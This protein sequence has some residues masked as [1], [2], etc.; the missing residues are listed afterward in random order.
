MRFYII[1]ATAAVLSWSTMPQAQTLVE[2]IRT[3]CSTE[4]KE[5][6]KAYNTGLKAERAGDIATAINLYS[7][8][9]KLDPGYCDAMDNLGRLYRV[10]NQYDKAEIVYK[11]SIELNGDNPAPYLNLAVVYS[12]QGNHQKAILQYNAVI[13]IDPYNPEGHYGLG[14]LY[15]DINKPKEAIHH[16]ELSEKLYAK[17]SSPY[18]DDARMMLSIAYAQTNDCEKAVDWADRLATKNRKQEIYSAIQSLCPDRLSKL[19]PSRDNSSRSAES[20]TKTKG[21]L[22]DGYLLKAEAGGPLAMHNLAVLLRSGKYSDSDFEGAAYLYRRAAEMGFAGSQNNLGDMYEVGEGVPKSTGDAIYW[23]TQAAMQGEPTAY[24]SLGYCFADGTGV[25]KDLV[26]AY[27]WLAL[28][29]DELPDG[30]N[31]EDAL[32][33]L[34]KVEEEMSGSEI[35]SAKERAVNFHPLKEATYKLGD[36]VTK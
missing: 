34:T 29:I 13:K 30:R 5:A 3:Y 19:K 28:A 33:K 7:A 35:T 36:R 6:S 20:P 25:L 16:L 2:P 22:Q 11:R 17:N 18:I 21:E 27:T 24:L 12:L 26:T 9:I 1:L 32:A 10:Q 15:T 23:Y 4:S 8:A 14:R 31:K